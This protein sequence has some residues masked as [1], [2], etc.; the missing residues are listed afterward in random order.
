MFQKTIFKLVLFVYLL[1]AVK[2]SSAQFYYGMQ[3]DFGKNR[4]QYQDFKWT[5]F[6]Y[7]RY[8][9]YT[10]QGGLELA[11]YVSVQVDKQLPILEK[12]LDF[13]LEDKI[14]VIVYNTQ[15]DFKQSNIGLANE[16]MNSNNVGGVTKII[17]DKVFVYFNGSHA[18]LDRQIRAA[19]AELMINQMLYGG[20]ARDMVRNSAVLNV[21]DWYTK[22]LIEYLS[23]G[24][25]SYAD[26]MVYD[27]IKNDNFIKFNRLNGKQA[28]QA[29][30]ALWYYVVDTYGDAVIPNLLY[31]T[32]V[33]RS[34][35][36]AFL[37]VLGV[38]L[39]NL[40]LDFIEAQNRRIFMFKD[41]TRVSPLQDNE[42]VKGVKKETEYYQMKISPDAQRVI[43]ATSKLSQY[44]VYVQ[45]INGGN[46]KR[47]L[48]FGAKLER[49]EDYN[50]PLLAWHPANTTVAMLYEAKGQILLHTVDLDSKD[51][52]KRPITGFKKINSIS[53][54]SDGK[55]LVMS[56]V[57]LGK[58][59]ADIFVFTLN[60]GG[61]EQLTN[62]VWDD[63]NPVF[64]KNNK[65]IVFESNRVNDTIKSTEDANPFA[66][67]S[68]NMDLFM[69]DYPFAKK[70]VLVRVTQTPDINETQPQ[71]YS[72]LK[73]AYLSER[74]GIYNRFIAEFDSTISY[75]DTTEHYR[76]FFNGRVIT[77]Y[78]RNIL[79]QHINTNRTHVAELVQANGK[80]HLLI[81]PIAKNS[82]TITLKPRE[83]WFR[84]G[85]RPS[86]TNP[87]KLTVDSSVGTETLTLGEDSKVNNTNTKGIDF[88]NYR[89]S[90]EKQTKDKLSEESEK[91]S[92]DSSVK[93][94]PTK[95]LEFKF[96]IQ[97]N[98]YTSFYND[99]VVTQFD[100][101]Y[102]NA[103]YQYFSGLGGPIYLNPG[104]NFLTKVSLSDLFEDQ[105]VIAAF[106][107]GGM[108]Q[109]FATSSFDNEQLLSWEFRRKQFDHKF[110]VHR[111]V[112]LDELF[113]L[114]TRDARYDIKYPFNEVS[115]VKASVLLRNDKVVVFSQSDATL[116]FKDQYNTMGALQAEYVFDN[117]RRVMLNIYNGWRLKV[118]G[119]YWQMP[120]SLDKQLIVGGFDVRHYQKV[121]RQ[122]TWC[123][124]L[125][126]GTSL[127]TDRLIYYLGGV[128]NWFGASF[129]RTINIVKPE[130]YTFQT[131]A[132]NMRG[133]RQN[134]RNGNNFLVFNSELRFPIVRYFANRN[135]KS[136]FLNNFQIIG[137]SDLGMAWYGWNPLSEENTLNKNSYSN[138][139]ITVIV[140]N[141]KSPLV[142]GVGFGFRSRILGYFMRFDVSWGIENLK[143]QKNINYFSLTTDF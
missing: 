73:V 99:N 74:N 42:M 58:G 71:E 110:M 47:L 15:S 85:V 20:R 69:A 80:P 4:I 78:D 57:K 101:S 81:R 131:L 79:E 97:K 29:G 135:L 55:K 108:G 49:L 52:V 10:Y 136:D 67:M 105:N 68:R 36:N 90:D 6:D 84:S 106:R 112:I 113:K 120:D 140:Y 37:F 119:Q 31:M 56:A 139:P 3:M 86:I 129:D 21:P 102:L 82:E 30:H 40:L 128:D 34:P 13:Q 61:V 96:P 137:F 98:Y 44:R 109:L 114:T 5:Y 17:G 116:A 91:P 28:K 33:S 92:G 77:N 32:K 65:H 38:S 103:T 76:Y 1:L 122:L 117:T 123:N 11:K 35:D 121:H 43:Y 26:N 16:M 64:I 104:L 9:V 124:R 130:Q 94:K 83:T 115:S 70:S 39:D 118:W 75:V 25:T 107:F 143:T 125:A 51:Q 127:G 141:E 62:D 111:Q 7:D 50:Y 87:E 27:G 18:D 54:S 14:Q 22:G 46:K 88:D 19:L 132:T 8:R 142:G 59:Q 66:K 72:K 138:G 24:W 12:R 134:I 23:Q 2:P 63:L 93:A 45:D 48:K 100:N 60:N 53:F 41:S 89:F 95:N 126:G 133:F